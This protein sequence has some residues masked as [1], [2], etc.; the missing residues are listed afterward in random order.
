MFNI[1]EA[2]IPRVRLGARDGPAEVLE[3][4]AMV[5][6]STRDILDGLA[7]EAG[8]GPGRRRDRVSRG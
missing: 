7:E 5:G 8:A 6:E 3:A 4:A 2:L 1:G